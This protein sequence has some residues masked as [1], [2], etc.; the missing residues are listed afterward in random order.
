LALTTQKE[1]DLGYT[2]NSLIER[3]YFYLFGNDHQKFVEE[4]KKKM[5]KIQT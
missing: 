1:L 4:K 3:N 5:V 2:Q